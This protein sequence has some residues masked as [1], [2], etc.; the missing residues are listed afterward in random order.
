M[1]FVTVSEH[2]Y[3]S[4]IDED[5]TE[6]RRNSAANWDE[7]MGCSWENLDDYAELEEAFLKYRKVD[8]YCQRCQGMIHCHMLD[9]GDDVTLCGNWLHIKNN[10]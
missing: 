2:T 7:L 6:Y 8:E 10:S 1:K 4:V 5:G 3:H 9:N